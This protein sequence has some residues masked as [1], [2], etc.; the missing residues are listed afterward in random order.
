MMMAAGAGVAGLSPMYT[1]FSKGPA[2]WLMT[3][4]EVN[5]L[6]VAKTDEE[7]QRVIDLFW[8]RRD[9]TPGTP[10]NEFREEFESRVAIADQDFK[11][12]GKRGSLTDLGRVFIIL[13]PPKGFSQLAGKILDTGMINVEGGGLASKE[14]GGRYTWDYPNPASGSLTG[15]LGFVE[16]TSGE[17]RYDTQQGNVAGAL[18]V[19]RPQAIVSTNLSA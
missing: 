10:R 5:A 9:P 7:A 6:R 12:R 19:A 16:S 11:F 2:Q 15:P 14:Q 17:Y 3:A 4:D 1:E 13:G 8:A 18:S